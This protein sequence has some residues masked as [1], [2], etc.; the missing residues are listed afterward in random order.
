MAAG[1]ALRLL[2]VTHRNQQGG[3]TGTMTIRHTA[4]G[5]PRRADGSTMGPTCVRVCGGP[6]GAGNGRM[7]FADKSVSP[8]RGRAIPPPPLIFHLP[9]FCH[10][11]AL[12]RI[13]V[14]CEKLIDNEA[15]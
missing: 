6:I 15:T 8:W 2:A 11:S 4:L 5:G 7:A 3:R 14:K 10:L 12:K 1:E 9:S 13:A